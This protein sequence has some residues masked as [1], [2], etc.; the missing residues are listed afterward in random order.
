MITR[1]TKIA[2]I[3]AIGLSLSACGTTESIVS[4]P[5][6]DT[7]ISSGDTF[8]HT[9]FKDISGHSIDLANTPGNKLIILFATWCTDSKRTFRA[10]N[11]S[12][13][14][15]SKDLT[16][17]AI[18]REENAETLGEFAKNYRIEFPLIADENRHI[19][20]QYA[21]KGIPRLILLDE[22]N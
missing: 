16:I 18:G 14:I 6:Y 11:Q 10:L 2:L 3:S 13:L 19:Y 22:N 7:Y 12:A 5:N 9:Q 8:K 20:N 21:N 15:H 4:T 17:L 1:H